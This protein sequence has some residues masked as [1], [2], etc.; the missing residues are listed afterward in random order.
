MVLDVY[1]PITPFE[2]FGD[3][4]LYSTRRELKEILEL[5]GVVS[6]VMYDDWI[7]YDIQ[8]SI[9]LLFHLKN[10]KLFRITALE[11]YRGK[12]F[13]KIG[14]GDAQEDLL[15]MEPSFV[16]DD[17]E[18]VWQSD[19]GVI[20]ETDAKD[21]TIKWISVFVEELDNDDFDRA[22]W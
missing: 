12:L 17:F 22:E 10:D 8:N 18:E 5:D 6:R 4:K 1:A 19:K 16:Y 14:I 21:N 11:N 7:I 20:I 2:G 15:K 13:D 3:I 9:E